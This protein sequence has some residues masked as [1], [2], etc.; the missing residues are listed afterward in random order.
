MITNSKLN[1]EYIILAHIYDDE[2][3]VDYN[4]M[5]SHCIIITLI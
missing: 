2:D 5:R 1:A 4:S 3:F